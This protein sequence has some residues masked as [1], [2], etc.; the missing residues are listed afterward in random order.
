MRFNGSILKVFMNGAWITWIYLFTI[1]IR[2]EYVDAKIG[3]RLI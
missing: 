1:F 2:L 3:K